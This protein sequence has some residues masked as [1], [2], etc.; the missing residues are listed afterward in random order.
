MCSLNKHTVYNILK[1]A[2]NEERLEA[3]PPSGRPR[4][5]SDRVERNAGELKEETVTR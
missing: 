2:E 5:I 3:K 4:K 1:R